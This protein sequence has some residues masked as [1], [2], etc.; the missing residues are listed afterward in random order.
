MFWY[1][2]LDYLDSQG[3]SKDFLKCMQVLLHTP[4]FDLAIVGRVNVQRHVVGIHCTQARL[5]DEPRVAAIQVFG[6]TEQ[7]TQDAH[8]L[9]RPGVQGSKLRMSLAG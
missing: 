6:Q 2:L 4:H 1:V 7:D 3:L 9:L 8:D 5:L